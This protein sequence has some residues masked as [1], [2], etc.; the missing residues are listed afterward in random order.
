VVMRRGR[1]RTVCARGASQAVVAG[2]SSSA[3]DAVEAP[4]WKSLSR[5]VWWIFSRLWAP[6]MAVGWPALALYGA[7]QPRVSDLDALRLGRAEAAVLIGSA[8]MQRS[9][10]VVPRD[11]PK[12][13]VSLVEDTA[14]KL[15]VTEHPGFGLIFLFVWALCVYGTWYFWIRPR[16]MAS[17]NRWS[18]P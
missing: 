9:Y 11:L 4:W 15:T 14:G 10:I 16:R 6:F 18:G 12:A 7:L 1:L 17:N 5:I 13:S 2:R 3:L 8:S